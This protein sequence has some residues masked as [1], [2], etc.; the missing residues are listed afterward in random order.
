MP[1]R[2]E[3]YLRHAAELL[4]SGDL[5]RAEGLERLARETLERL[6][7]PPQLA[8]KLHA[9]RGDRAMRQAD[10]PQAE[11]AFGD[12]LEALREAGGEPRERFELLQR[13]G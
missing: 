5:A 13:L 11:S 4:R 10:Y 12:A 3:S 8:A 7:S 6:G 2:F 1:D 9:L